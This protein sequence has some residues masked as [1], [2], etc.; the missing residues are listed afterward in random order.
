MT[1]LTTLFTTIKTVGWKLMLPALV[2]FAPVKWII[3]LVIIAI[4]VDTGFGIWSSKKTGKDITSS[5][6]SAVIGKMFVYSSVILLFFGIDVV[7]LGDFVKLII[8]INYTVTK[9]VA[10]VLLSVEGYSIDEKLK[11]V[12]KDKGI[13]YYVKRTLGLAKKLKREAEV[14]G[15]T[16]E[17]EKEV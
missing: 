9:L 11:N 2:F 13:W 4:L 3:L 16:D 1:H 12:N 6:A 8:G 17:K 7:I 10:L 15:V 5:R 14:L